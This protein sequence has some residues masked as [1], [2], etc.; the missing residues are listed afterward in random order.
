MR[1]LRRFLALPA[2]ERGLLLRA[3]ILLSGVRLGLWLLPFQALRRFLARLAQVPA[4][5]RGARSLSPGRI[6]WAVGAA[7]RIVPGTGTCLVRALAA[8]VLLARRGHPAQ[9]RL[10]VARNEKGRLEAHAWLETQGAI[11]IGGEESPS[12]F[13]P[14]PPLEGG[15]PW[16]RS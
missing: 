7:S 14:L 5:G 13:A 3:A 6:V 8:Q 16:A 10:G 4:H 15:R 1:R 12:H 11:V 9:L 2:P